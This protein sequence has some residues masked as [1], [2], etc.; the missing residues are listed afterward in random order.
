MNIR[1]NVFYVACEKAVYICWE[2]INGIEEYR[3]Y[4]DGIEIANSN[5]NEFV[6]PYVFDNDH[7]TELFK[8]ATRNW[9]YFMDFYIQDFQAYRYHIEGEGGAVS[10]TKS[11]VTEIKTY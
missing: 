11:L 9:L 6:R 8:P 2:K 3:I 4:R 5:D 10:L 7:H 1:A